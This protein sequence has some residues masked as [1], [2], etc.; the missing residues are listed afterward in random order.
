[1]NGLD[2]LFIVLFVVVVVIILTSTSDTA[3]PGSYTRPPPE[4]SGLSYEVRVAMLKNRLNEFGLRYIENC[5]D[6]NCFYQSVSMAMSGPA[7]SLDF[8]KKRGRVIKKNILD[9]LTNKEN[10]MEAFG[11][12]VPHTKKDYLQDHTNNPYKWA[13][14]AIIHGFCD[15]YNANVTLINERGVVTNL[16]PRLGLHQ[17][18][19]GIDVVLGY[20]SFQHVVYAEPI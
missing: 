7:Q 20:I 16:T 11:A 13:D 1:M 12:Y 4:S 8:H 19:P 2:T 9:Y 18:K 14:T 3:Q 17:S 10:Y 15:V 5:A 6:G